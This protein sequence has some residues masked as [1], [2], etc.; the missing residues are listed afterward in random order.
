VNGADIDILE[1]VK[2]LA[3]VDDHRD[4]VDVA[5]GPQELG[6]EQV[7]A[8]AAGRNHRPIDVHS[9]LPEPTTVVD[10]RLSGLD[11]SPGRRPNR[12]GI[13]AE[14]QH[15]SLLVQIRRHPEG[16]FVTNDD[17]ASGA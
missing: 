3:V 2:V 16:G 13:G 4:V 6:D 5:D 8:V 9:V 7:L 17:D 1:E 11:T 12:S 15:L 10:S 14:Q